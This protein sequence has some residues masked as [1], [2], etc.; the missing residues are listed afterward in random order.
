M[1]VGIEVLGCGEQ[2][3]GEQALEMGRNQDALIDYARRPVC[4]FR[5]PRDCK[6]PAL[7]VKDS[8]GPNLEIYSG[9]LG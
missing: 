6:V 1:V 5:I 8:R 9:K 2:W 4:Q 7:T 3:V